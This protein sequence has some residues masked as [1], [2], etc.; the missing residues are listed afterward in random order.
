[1]DIW[2]F[3][4]PPGVWEL[5]EPIHVPKGQRVIGSG[6]ANTFLKS[7]LPAG[8]A[9]LNYKDCERGHGGLVQ[10]LSIHIVHEG[11][12]GIELVDCKAVRIQNVLIRYARNIRLG[13]DGLRIIGHRSLSAYC[14]IDQLDV[15]LC[16]NGVWLDTVVD[17]T[18][19]C[20]RHKFI[21]PI[22]WNC[23]IGIRYAA[24][25][26]N[27]ISGGR[28]ESCDRPMYF[29]KRSHRNVFDL[30]EENCKQK[31]YVEVGATDN[32]PDEVRSI[33]RGFEFETRDLRNRI[34]ERFS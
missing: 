2:K 34:N 10:D 32:R 8:V 6:R 1:M 28:F 21:S 26:T 24:S 27:E 15:M 31:V 9:L 17:G 4:I 16:N 23:G 25:C 33:W 5:R 13:G 19:I 29:S 14:H 22:F 11:S 12:H 18:P 30:I 20:N 7:Y 3:Q